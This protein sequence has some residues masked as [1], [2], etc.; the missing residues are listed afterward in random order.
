MEN[1]V[2]NFNEQYKKEWRAL[3]FYYEFKDESKIWLVVGS[4]IGLSNFCSLLNRYTN[5]SEKNKLSEHQHLGP[6]AYLKIVTWNEPELNESGIYGTLED[7]KKLSKLIFIKLKNCH[8]GDIFIIDKEY[9]FNNK[10]IFRIVVREDQ[11]DPSTLD[12]TL[13]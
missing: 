2:F 12:N 9:S 3:G 4:R 6:H 10:C 7:I 5:N 13:V 8:Q 1:K 11:F